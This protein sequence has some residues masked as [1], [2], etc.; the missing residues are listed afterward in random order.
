MTNLTEQRILVTGG[1]GGIGYQTALTLAKM[2]AA[3]S[4]TGRAAPAGKQAAQT[5]IRESGNERVTFLRADLS[6][7]AGVRGLAGEVIA[8]HPRLHVLINNA[9]TF[10]P[11]RI[12]TEDDIELNFAVNV[13]A[14]FVLTTSLFG[15]LQQSSP[16]RV[17]T[18]MGGDI[19]RKMELD[20]LQAERSFVGIN[21]Y[22]ASK[23]AML[24]LMSELA[25]RQGGKGV[26]INVCYPGQAF[27]NMVT[28]L[29]PTTVPA[30]MRLLLPL[31]GLFARVDGG[32]SAKHA[33]RSS[34]YLATDP[35]V[36]GINGA[37]FTTEMKQV[38]AVA[39]SLDPANRAYL[40]QLATRLAAG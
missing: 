21:S 32:R 8:T 1:S 18:L 22:S 34:V 11:R 16:A 15:L 27:T 10:A 29:D 3:V 39:A 4:I 33:S 30:P 40:W 17:I 2:G 6:T 5:I 23:V 28:K 38:P 36:Q 9:G 13:M 37:Y 24:T 20:N 12:L 14:P 7:L 35:A 19:T 31:L 25:D 26:D